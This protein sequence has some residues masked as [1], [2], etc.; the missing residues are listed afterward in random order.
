MSGW[1][2]LFVVG[3]FREESSLQGLSK[4]SVLETVLSIHSFTST[5]LNMLLNQKCSVVS[6]C[7]SCVG[8]N[9]ILH[10]IIHMY[11]ASLQYVHMHTCKSIE[12]VC[13]CVCV[14]FCYRYSTLCVT[15]MNLWT[16]SWTTWAPRPSWTSYCRWWLLP[17]T[18]RPALTLHRYIYKYTTHT[19]LSILMYIIAVHIVSACVS[20]PC[21]VCTEVVR[22]GSLQLNLQFSLSG[23]GTEYIYTVCT[24]TLQ[25]LHMLLG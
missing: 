12:F 19:D 1:W 11:T 17:A 20:T 21:I 5:V 22:D 7:V 18:T 4:Y 8:A 16:C 15:R 2:L 13:V 24:Y 23:G 3:M 14:M 25:Y 10:C 6:V 9:T